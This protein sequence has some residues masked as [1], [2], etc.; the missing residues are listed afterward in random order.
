MFPGGEGVEVPL[1]ANL[2]RPSDLN[3]FIGVVDH[4]I[5]L[6]GQEEQRGERN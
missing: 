5:I 6:A 1:S 3:T 4:L 2:P